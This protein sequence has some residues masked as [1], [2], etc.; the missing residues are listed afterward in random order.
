MVKINENTYVLYLPFP[1]T[2]LPLTYPL[3]STLL[4]FLRLFFSLTRSWNSKWRERGV[5]YC[6]N[7]LESRVQSPVLILDYA[8]DKG[9]YV[10]VTV[11]CP[12][13]IVYYG[14][15]GMTGRVQSWAALSLFQYI[16]LYM[17]WVRCLPAKWVKPLG[18]HLVGI[19]TFF[20]ICE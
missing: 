16:L 4:S 8:S 3:P 1:P 6:A 10:A 13:F 5:W 20:T 2:P 12:Y 9:C 15:S 19:S 17:F 18:C 14:K 11:D 7:N